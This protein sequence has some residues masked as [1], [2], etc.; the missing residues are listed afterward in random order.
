MTAFAARIASRSEQSAL[1]VP[2]FVSAIFVTVKG[3]ALTEYAAK[4]IASAK[5]KLATDLTMFSL[6]RLKKK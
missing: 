4:S 5:Q 2:S 6:L 1:Q 3:A